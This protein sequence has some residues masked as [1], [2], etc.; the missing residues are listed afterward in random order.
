MNDM[1]FIRLTGC[2]NELWLKASAIESF[3]STPEGGSIVRTCGGQTH[4]VEEE[5]R[6]IFDLIT[7]AAHL[8]LEPGERL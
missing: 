3:Y 4:V 5:W 2:G 7:K 8:P 1:A 6:Y